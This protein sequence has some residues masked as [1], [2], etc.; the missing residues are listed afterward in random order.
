MAADILVVDDEVDIRD[1]VAGILSDEGHETRTAF[2]ADSALAA[3]N[4]RAPRLVFLDIWLQG[5]RL[6]GLA[7]LDEIKK[8]HPELPVVMISGHGNIET[9]VSAIR[10]GAYDFIEK[11][12]KADR[13]IL[14]AERALETSKLKRE[15]SDL[16]KRTGDQLELVGTSL[17]MNQLRQTIERVAPANSRIMITGPSG[18]GKELV[19]R[20]IHAQSSRA[21][22]PFVT[23]NA[24]TITP[25]RM[26]IELFGTEMDGGER[27]VGALEEA[28]GGILYLDEVA[29]MPRETQNKILRVLV[30]QQF[31]RV[32][33]TKRVKVDV[34]IISSTA[35]NLEGMIAEGTF[36]EDLFHRLSVVPVQVPALAAR[37]EDIPSLVEF[38]MKQIAEQAG[39]KPRK[40]GPDAMAV[41]QA[42]SWP[43]NLRQLRNNVERLMILTRGD[44]PDELV[45][46]DLLPAEIGDTLPRAPT[47]SDQHIMA[48]PLR[49]ARERFEKEYLIAQINRF[50]GN[51]SRTAEF[52][53]M[54]RS[55]LH[56]KLKSLGV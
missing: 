26:E 36:R 25:E 17:A 12:F 35:Q 33:G 15:V 43:G 20:A 44:D 2:D 3:I 14:V 29:D 30:D 51:I 18:A 42:H 40:I 34:R 37:R 10:R 6:D 28:H 41:L 21:N 1:L 52:V 7:L 11:P 54:E 32:G 50:G 45:T 47:E 49:E 5:S 23:V 13:L 53:G 56:R 27:K 24:A 55:A 48:L 22:G 46:A 19:A 38:F 31:E 9:A 16:R 4:D 39:I 8:Q